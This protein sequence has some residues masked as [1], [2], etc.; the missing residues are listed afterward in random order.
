MIQSINWRINGC[1][2]RPIRLPLLNQWAISGPFQTLPC[3]SAHWKPIRNS[4][5][6]NSIM[7][8]YINCLWSLVASVQNVVARMLL[9]L[10]WGKGRWSI[11]YGSLMNIIAKIVATL[12]YIERVNWCVSK[13]TPWLAYFEGFKLKVKYTESNSSA[14][15]KKILLWRISTSVFL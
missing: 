13:G 5:S 12:K 4:L 8:G 6:M 11:S 10:R 9:Y 7:Y 14:D 2:H 1:L 15:R 3:D